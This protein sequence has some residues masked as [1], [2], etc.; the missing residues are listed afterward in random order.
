MSILKLEW[1]FYYFWINTLKNLTEFDSWKRQ[2]F[3]YLFKSTK[4]NFEILE[5]THGWITVNL[6]LWF[7]FHSYFIIYEAFVI[8]LKTIEKK[9][10]LFTNFV[11]FGVSNRS[12]RL[13]N[14][15]VFGIIA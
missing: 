9:V 10:I 15:T 4:I 7:Q 14:I 13:I 8:K 3:S 11:S 12:S 5:L 1:E 2:N 6:S